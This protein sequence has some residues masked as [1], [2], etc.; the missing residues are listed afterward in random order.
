ML[1]RVCDRCG[2]EIKATYWFK[3]DCN[4]MRS[5]G[6]IYCDTGGYELCEKCFSDF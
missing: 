5:N 2:E 1:K 4:K 3:I 6:S